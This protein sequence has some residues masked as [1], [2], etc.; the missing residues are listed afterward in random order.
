MVDVVRAELPTIDLV[1]RGRASYKR[2]CAAPGDR[3]VRGIIREPSCC[4]LRLV[5]SVKRFNGG[6]GG[7]D[8]MIP[9]CQQD[10]RIGKLRS[11]N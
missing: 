4:D 10:I 8:Y 11:T 9:M 6:D 1:R 2:G 3:V 5:C 7:D